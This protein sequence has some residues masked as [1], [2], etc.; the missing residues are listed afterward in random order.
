[1]PRLQFEEGFFSTLVLGGLIF[2]FKG[3]RM[4]FLFFSSLFLKGHSFITCSPLNH[5]HPAK[6]LAVTAFLNSSP[7]V[8]KEAESLDLDVGICH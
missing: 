6:Q 4:I 7:G 5:A 3:E 8:E 1:M 2:F